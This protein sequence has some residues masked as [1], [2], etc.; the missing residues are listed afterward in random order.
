MFTHLRF[1]PSSAFCIFLLSIKEEIKGH[2]VE[3]VRSWRLSDLQ[4]Q[5]VVN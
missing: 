3:A 1:S 4:Q 2:N 5:L